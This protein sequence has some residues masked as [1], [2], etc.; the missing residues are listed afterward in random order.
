MPRSDGSKRMWTMKAVCENCHAEVPVRTLGFLRHAYYDLGGGTVAPS[1][2]DLGTCASCNGF[3]MV[4][5][6]PTDPEI[7]RWCD[8]TGRDADAVE[9][10][11]LRAARNRDA[12]KEWAAERSAIGTLCCVVC[13]TPGAHGAGCRYFD[14][15]GDTG[16]R[17]ERCGGRFRMQRD[18]HF[19]LRRDA[20]SSPREVVWLDRYG[21]PA[22]R[23]PLPAGYEA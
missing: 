12:W 11:D 20:L 4:E 16:R 3:S 14:E 6:I 13:G 5:R 15:G 10:L 8:G 21:R 22:E 7:D 18:T 9:E 19:M 17:H 1:W 2:D 23:A